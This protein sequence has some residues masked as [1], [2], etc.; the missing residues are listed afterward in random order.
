MSFVSG[1]EQED[2][3]SVRALPNL[4]LQQTGC[5]RCSHSGC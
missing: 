2:R 3:D 5:P 4:R 1:N